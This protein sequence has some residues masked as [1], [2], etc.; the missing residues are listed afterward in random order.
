MQD[1]GEL[2]SFFII[3]IYIY[4]SLYLQKNH[5]NR[6]MSRNMKGQTTG[7]LQAIWSRLNQI[8]SSGVDVCNDRFMN[9][10][11]YFLQVHTLRVTDM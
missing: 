5:L 11:Y 2:T 1:R 4:K 3:Y 10:L 8:L 7:K 6:N 9:L